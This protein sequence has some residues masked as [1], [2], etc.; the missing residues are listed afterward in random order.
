MA[1][2]VLFGLSNVVK[3]RE[4]DDLQHWKL[5]ESLQLLGFLTS[6]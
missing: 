5:N 4:S 1:R 2:R 3:H 6:G